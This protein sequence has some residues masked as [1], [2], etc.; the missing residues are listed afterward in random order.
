ML[1]ICQAAGLNLYINNEVLCVLQFFYSQLSKSDLVTIAIEFYTTEG[2]ATAKNTLF[3]TAKG[4]YP[5]NV[6]Q[7]VAR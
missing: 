6:H 2:I 5:D 7:P 3:T 1:A 4:A